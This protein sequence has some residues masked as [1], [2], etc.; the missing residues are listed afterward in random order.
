[1]KGVIARLLVFFLGIPAIVAI[2]FYL[3]G[4]NSIGISL[5]VCLFSGVGGIEISALFQ[6]GRSLT[7]KIA[8]FLIAFL[9]PFMGYLDGLSLL[10]PGAF[11]FCAAAFVIIVMTSEVFSK[12]ASIPRILERVSSLFFPFLYPG[13]LALFLVRIGARADS[14]SLYLLF[15]AICF[16]NDSAAWFFGMLLGKKR[17]I[18]PVSP[19]KS[20]AGFIGGIVLSIVSPIIFALASPLHFQGPLWRWAL[21]GFLCGLAVIFGD[22]AESAIK[23]SAG[24][25]DSGA[26]VPGRG[27]VL[28]SIDS[29]LFAAPVFLASYQILFP[30]P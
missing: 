6:Q 18:V 1:V 20:V 9:V 4:Y 27:G 5:M 7:R 28:D 25:K 11:A 12:A 29:L 26:I 22:L 23:R 16:G 14:V 8:A 13:V 24:V 15:F 21:L 3:R 10:P 2:A 30:V 17:N 19:N